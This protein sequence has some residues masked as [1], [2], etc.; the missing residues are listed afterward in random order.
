[1][2]YLKSF[3]EELRIKKTIDQKKLEEFCGDYLV[4]LY[5]GH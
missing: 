4:V 5:Q 3:N 2:I 1:M